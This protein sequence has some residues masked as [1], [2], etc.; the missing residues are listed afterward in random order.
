MSKKNLVILLIFYLVSS[1]ISFFSFSYFSKE[2]VVAVNEPATEPKESILGGLLDIDPN[3]PRDQACPLNG[4]YYTLTE[5]KAW[6]TRRPLFVMIENSPD[7][8]PHSGL[9]RADVVFEAVAEGG[10]TRFGALYYCAA[11]NE[12][13]VIAPVR[14]ARTYF[15]DWAS[16]FNL[17]MYVHVGGANLS[18]P[19][20]A[21]G[22]IADYGWRGENDMDQFSIGYPT[23][24]R[25]Y[26]RIP[27]K[28]VDTEHTMQTDTEALWAVAADRGWTNITPERVVNR[29]TIPATPWQEGYQGWTFED[30]VGE[31]G[32]VR[33]ISYDFWTGYNQFSVE[34]NYDIDLDGYIRTNG[35]EVQYDLNNDEPIAPKTVIVL[36]TTEKGPINE[37]KH[38]LY[39]T[40]G[41]GK[42]LIFKHGQEPIEANWSKPSREAE[43]QFTDVR[44]KAVE[45]ARGQIWISVLATGSEIVY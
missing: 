38:M 10:V 22:Q 32:A 24:I 5:K 29:Q 3:E 4:K 16:G 45:L 25:N 44:G 14:S 39:T 40:I 26:S 7:A 30:E 2:K 1:V 37:L 35:G 21:L 27:D 17:P 19:S 34:W 15:V 12:N 41:K 23:F 33:K 11:Q 6:E 43:L 42:A 13:V 20:N 28:E 31:P 8:R 36:L 9:S 18:G